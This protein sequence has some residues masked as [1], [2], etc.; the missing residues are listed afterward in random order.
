MTSWDVVIVGAGPAGAALACR[1]RPRHRVLLLERLHALA[2]P[3]AAPRIGE[4][5]PGAARVLLQRLG[6]F[7]RFLAQGHAERGASVSQ[8]ESDTPVW[9]DAVRDPQGAGWHLDRR[10]F[11]AG[12]RE[13]AEAAGAVLMDSGR[14]LHVSHDHGRWRIHLQGPGAAPGTHE[15]PVLVDASGRRRV[16]ARQL[17]LARQEEDPLICLYVHLPADAGDADQA[18]R[19]CADTNGWWYSVRVPS[20]QRV[21]AFHLDRG[22]P[23]LQALRDPARLLAKARRHALLAG[24]RPAGAQVRVHAQPAG[25]A[26]PE[27]GALAALPEGFFAVGDAMRAFDPIASQGLFNALATAE[28]V[29]HA[30]TQHADGVKGA[31]D[32]HLD[33]MRAV[34][35]RHDQRLR[36]TYAAVTR[37]AREPFWQR[38]T[39]GTMAGRPAPGPLTLQPVPG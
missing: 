28:G 25:G 11:D 38:R 14:H 17:G 4:S 6:V 34:Q 35:A 22:D 39:R 20:G 1:L 33:E 2:G 32:R 24:I 19:I 8:W 29:A 9:F 16:A 30:V 5:L 36:E 27:P 31:R 3:P 10:R 37:Y 21:L 18:T 7:D 15:A 13:A 23:E 26:G 12:L